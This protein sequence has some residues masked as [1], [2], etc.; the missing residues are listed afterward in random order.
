MKKLLTALVLLFNVIYGFSQ[1]AS[2]KKLSLNDLSSF[3]P[4]AGNWF[5]AGDVTMDRNIDEH[6]APE[7]AAPVKKRRR[8]KMTPTLAEAPHAVSFENGKGI[9][10]NIPTKDKKDNLVT[11][12]V[13]GDIELELEVML[14]RGS[15]S[16]IYLQGGYEVQ[17]YDSWGVK[18]AGFSDI[19][20]IYRNWENVPG[21]IYMGKAPL[22][23]AAKAPGLWQKFKIAFRAPRFNDKGEKIANARFLSVELNGVRIHDNVEVPQLTGGPLDDKEKPLG[24]LMIQGDHGA[25]AIRNIKYRLLQDAEVSLSD[26]SFKVF[27]GKF[28]A[29]ENFVTKAP[30]STGTTPELTWEVA[31]T[32]D[33]FGVVFNGSLTVNRDDDYDFQLAFNGGALLTIDDNL[34][35]VNEENDNTAHISLKKGVYP[36]QIVYY[37]NV[38]WE[39]PRLGLTVSGASSYPKVLNAFNS[40]P[41]DGDL[42]SPILVRV[43]S[44]PRLLRA[45]LDFKGDRS[46]RLTHTIAVGEPG[47]IHYIYDLK[48]G[49]LVC[50]WRG[51]FVDATPMWHDRGDGSFLPLGIIQY[52]FSGPGLAVLADMNAPFPS[53]SD[54]KDFRG[55][56]YTVNGR[57]VFAYTY[58]GV[59]VSDKI[60]PDTSNKIFTRE[61]SFK[62]FSL[63]SAYFK[64][65]EGSLITLLP[66][67]SYAVD[68][69]SYYITAAPGLSPMIREQAGK[70]ELVVKADGNPIKYSIIW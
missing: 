29:P 58:K 17:L 27:R 36:F 39:A 24:P 25:V 5:I 53:I 54:E 68:D 10:I 38:D 18:N 62:N 40:F 59:E 23:N 61:I 1:D 2:M 63:S 44:E 21:K 46:K 7:T 6:H 16:G 20:G 66:D 47:G 70:K 35:P 51:D 26:I 31:G 67:G 48:A 49:N 50:V 64:L 4:N 14:P 42:S 56:G 9:L 12:W 37:K 57:P 60:F 55:N 65:A 30:D 13:H 43:G 33:G 19:G 41:P 22:S 69:K 34:L 32:D 11:S 45:F 3:K 52:L 28:D 8:N 15:N